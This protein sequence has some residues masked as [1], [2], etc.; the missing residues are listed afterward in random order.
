MAPLELELLELL[1]PP[2]LELLELDESPPLLLELEPLPEVVSSPVVVP[3]PGTRQ[4]PCA[5]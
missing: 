5:S 3:S 2:E 1:E 4:N